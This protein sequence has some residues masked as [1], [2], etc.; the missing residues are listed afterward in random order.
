MSQKLV[1]VVISIL[2]QKVQTGLVSSGE[3]GAHP[4]PELIK[5][6]SDMVKWIEFLI[7]L[8]QRDDSGK[9]AIK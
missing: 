5:T 3:N 1:L 7:Q 6:R 4:W 9:S 8:V 2:S